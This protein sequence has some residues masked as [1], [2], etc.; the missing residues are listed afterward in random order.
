MRFGDKVRALR[1]QK[2]LLMT[3]VCKAMG[4]SLSYM[5]EIET[6]HQR[7]PGTAKIK[8]LSQ[9]LK[10]ESELPELLRL[11]QSAKHL[12]TLKLNL[13]NQSD[14]EVAEAIFN[15]VQAYTAGRI[16]AT[17]ARRISRALEHTT[18]VA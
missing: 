9:A 4:V 11:G 17:V 10:A 5:S 16:N 7:P 13:G 15:L 2:G 8:Q 3:D 12:V 18:A 14:P 1:M 6:S